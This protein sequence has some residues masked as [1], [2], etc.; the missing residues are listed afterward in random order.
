MDE[1]VAV[2]VG[3]QMEDGYWE[4]RVVVRDQ[5]ATKNRRQ[6]IG[7]E[8]KEKTGGIDRDRIKKKNTYGG[9]DGWIDKENPDSSTP[10]HV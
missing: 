9:M 7:R 4:N 5:P 8:T 2:V 3:Q 10:Q 1:L 6:D